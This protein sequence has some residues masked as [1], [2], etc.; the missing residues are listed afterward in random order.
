MKPTK[1]GIYEWTDQNNVKKLVD[2][3]DVGYST[4]YLR[5][6][7][8]GGYYNVNDED[9]DNPAEWPDRWGNFV[10]EQGSV[11]EEQI[12]SLP[13]PEERKKIFDKQ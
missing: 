8:W 12:Y 9:N 1:P 4:P 5:V 6:A 13:T 7:F 3:C 10:G 11:P 2:V